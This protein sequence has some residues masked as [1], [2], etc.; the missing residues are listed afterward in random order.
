MENRRDGTELG[1]E[2]QVGAGGAPVEKGHGDQ[3]VTGPEQLEP[4]AQVEALRRVG[5]VAPG[6]GASEAR[7]LP[8]GEV[9]G[10]DPDTIQVGHEA[11]VVFHLEH[12]VGELGARLPRE[13]VAEKHGSAPL[14]HRGPVVAVAVAEAGAPASPCGV[15]ETGEVPVG[16]RPGVL[17]RAHQVAP[18]RLERDEARI[19]RGGGVGESHRRRL[20]PIL[21]RAPDDQVFAGAD[22][23]ARK[24]PEPRRR[25]GVAQ[26][27]ARQIHREGCE[28]D[29]LD[30]VRAVPVVVD[31][32]F[33]VGRED[34]VDPD[35]RREARGSQEDD[36][37]VE[38]D[39]R[40]S[41]PGVGGGRHSGSLSETHGAPSGLSAWR[42]A[43]HCT[44]D[45]SGTRPRSQRRSDAPAGTATGDRADSH[46]DPGPPRGVQWPRISRRERRRGSIRPRE[47][48]PRRA[49]HPR[50]TEDGR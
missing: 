50:R 8:D 10:E 18:L 34:L 39:E 17:G 20:G 35:L 29:E 1:D 2:R 42:R 16:R 21:P 28:V 38:G 49:F 40:R 13:R 48:F 47:W 41:T 27:V 31:D 33:A 7:L 36:K 12:Q 15:V 9:H 3:V 30:P 19:E 24:R 43:N 46:R 4:G 11:V 6:R 25:R 14:R 37:Q 44:R 26:A 5:L 45:E 23:R 22:D 32:G